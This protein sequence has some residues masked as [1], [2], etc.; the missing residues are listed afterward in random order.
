MRLVN[1]FLCQILDFSQYGL[2]AIPGWLLV[3]VS[4]DRFI[5]IAYPRRFTFFFNRSFQWA[6]IACV[7]IYQPIYYSFM[8]W[9]SQLQSSGSTADTA[10]NGTVIVTVTCVNNAAQLLG[11]MDLFNSTIVPFALMIGFSAALIYHIKKSRNRINIAT[12]QGHNRERARDRKFA[13]TALA[14]NF[15]YLAFNLP[16]VIENLLVAYL[17]IEQG[18]GNFLYFFI[19]TLFYTFYATDFYVQFVANS[20]FREQFFLLFKLRVVRVDAGTTTTTT[21]YAAAAGTGSMNQSATRN[22]LRSNN[23]P[24]RTTTGIGNLT[25]E[26]TQT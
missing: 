3:A 25:V 22:K 8:I 21:K 15:I 19:A 9:N 20:I 10:D 14:L 4:I 5:N 6:L 16:V 17:T 13:V 11:W 24:A 1:G 12:Q 18:V 2:N 7:T 26:E 23:E